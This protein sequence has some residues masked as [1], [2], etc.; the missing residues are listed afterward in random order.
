MSSLSGLDIK[1]SIKSKTFLFNN[2]K[3]HHFA[4]FP[5][6]KKNSSVFLDL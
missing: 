3:K 4:G 5:I 6:R 1:L 2:M